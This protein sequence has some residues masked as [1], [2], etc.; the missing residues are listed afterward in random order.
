[1]TVGR[2]IFVDVV[3]ASSVSCRESSAGDIPARRS[4]A[5]GMEVLIS[6]G[7]SVR[8]E[9]VSEPVAMVDRVVFVESWTIEGFTASLG[10]DSLTSV[11]WRFVALI[12][13][14]G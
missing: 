2:V 8:G 3:T 11:D 13:K 10:D 14:T 7:R 5:G 12:G 9:S 4:A 6:L 1:M